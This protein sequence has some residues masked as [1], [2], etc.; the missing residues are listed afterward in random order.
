MPAIRSAFSNASS[1]IDIQPDVGDLERDVR[2]DAFLREGLQ[3]SAVLIGRF[4][5]LRAAAHAFA[6]DAASHRKPASIEFFG[7][8]QEIAG[9]F[10]G[11]ESFC[12]HGKAVAADNALYEPIVSRRKNCRPERPIEDRCH[13]SRIQS[14]Q[15]GCLRYPADCHDV[16]TAPHI[17]MQALRLI[18]GLIER[19]HHFAFEALVDLVFFPEVLLQVLHP[20]QV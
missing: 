7:D 20:F 6:Q 19:A 1:R 2:V 18:V 14:A 13:E 17:D 15:F 9:G 4:D 16:G 11:D 8:S 12:T 5:C 10:A 3:Q